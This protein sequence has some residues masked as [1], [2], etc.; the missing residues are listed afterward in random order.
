M[1]KIFS[2]LSIALFAAPAGAVDWW[3]MPTICQPDNT[4]C[5]ASMGAGFDSEEWDVGGNCK[6][7]KL[8]CPNAIHVASPYYPAYSPVAMSKAE[9]ADKGL[10]DNDF[11]TNA[12]NTDGGCFGARK[13]R[14]NGTQAKVGTE[15]RNVYCKGILDSPD[16][17]LPTGEVMTSLA[18][19]PTC[20]TLKADGFIGVL[21][22]QCY[23][24]F[25][26]PESDFYLECEGNELLP[27][28]I[29]VLNGANAEKGDPSVP[30]PSAIYP[31]T[32]EAASE[33]FEQM[34]KA[35]A[36]KQREHAAVEP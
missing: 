29:V 7:K 24:K 30:Q 3:T 20:K 26:Y 22:G 18:D 25:G 16:D 10:V 32:E 2:I 17:T 5:Y 1:K 11:D 31:K 33:R 13:T 6:G 21:N 14:N 28:K 8:I 27:S 35:A 15:W 34:L 12:L 23:G 36:E 9:V 19:Q 4:K